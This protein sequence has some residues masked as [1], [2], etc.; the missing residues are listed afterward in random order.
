MLVAVTSG[1]DVGE[2]PVSGEFGS[3][4]D[5]TGGS[6][7]DVGEGGADGGYCGTAG[8]WV[9]DCWCMCFGLGDWFLGCWCRRWCVCYVVGCVGFDSDYWTV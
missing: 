7:V 9:G 8:M 3:L 6:E 4:C 5:G 1:D 2:L